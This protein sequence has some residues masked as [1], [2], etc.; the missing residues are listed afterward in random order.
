MTT[1]SPMDR[2]RELAEQAVEEAAAQLGQVR[3]AHSQAQAQLDQLLN[4]ENE[5]RA[6]LQHNLTQNGVRAANW[7]NYQQFMTTLD[8]TIHAHRQQVAQCQT[9]LQQALAEWRQKKQR[10][11]AFE[12]LRDRAETVRLMQ[13][14]RQDQK[15]MDEY[16][17]RASQRKVT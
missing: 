7:I 16:A 2:L 11:N 14:T 9:R 1:L 4:Y 17:Q 12:T 10:L 5:Y 15:L 3:Q 6:Q 8:N 13:Q